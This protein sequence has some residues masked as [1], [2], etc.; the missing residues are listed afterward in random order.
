MSFPEIRALREL[1]I[2]EVGDLADS[3]V[4]SHQ[5]A[6]TTRELE[7]RREQGGR[8]RFVFPKDKIRAVCIKCGEEIAQNRVDAY[9]ED[10]STDHFRAVPLRCASCESKRKPKRES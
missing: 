7:L 6:L 1:G 10:F 2:R 3:A 4:S 9:D 5:V 8:L